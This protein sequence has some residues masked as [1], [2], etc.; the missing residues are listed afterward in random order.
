MVLLLYIVLERCHLGELGLHMLHCIG[1]FQ[2]GW[3]DG[4][5]FPLLSSPLV[6]SI[7]LSL[8]FGSVVD[9]RVVS[10]VYLSM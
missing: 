10:N 2:N 8:V 7:I 9:V 1:T 3:M 5:G 6:C 4:S